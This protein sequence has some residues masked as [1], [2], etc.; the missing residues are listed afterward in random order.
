M[1]ES[2]DL[3]LSS[4]GDGTTTD[5][6]LANLR[7][8]RL[9]FPTLD[10]TKIMTKNSLVAPAHNSNLHRCVHNKLKPVVM[11]NYKTLTLLQCM[12]LIQFG[13]T[14][15]TFSCP[16]SKHVSTKHGTYHV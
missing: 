7:V 1:G 15:L 2:K 14:L 4:L 12:T 10:V 5:D 13:Q 3:N 11:P 16:S 8:E 9:P 6:L